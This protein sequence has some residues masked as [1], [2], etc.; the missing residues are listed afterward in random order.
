[1]PRP[2]RSRPRSRLPVRT[3]QMET[4]A[5]RKETYPAIR[6]PR[7]VR[8]ASTCRRS[9]LALGLSLLPVLAAA[10]VGDAKTIA[11][12]LSNPRGIAFT[13]SGE[14]YVAEAGMG[15]P[16]PCIPSPVQPVNRCYGE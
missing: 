10:D 3:T 6:R 9:L 16:G 5:M 14:L 1:V 4:Y 11:S 12:G 13:A 15:G 2:D 7:E 8:P